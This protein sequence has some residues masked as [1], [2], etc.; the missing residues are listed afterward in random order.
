MAK[1]LCSKTN[2]NKI[3]FGL[4]SEESILMVI[5]LKLEFVPYSSY[6]STCQKIKRVKKLM[7]AH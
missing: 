6:F 7:H 1:L 3:I 2:K 4:V 5:L